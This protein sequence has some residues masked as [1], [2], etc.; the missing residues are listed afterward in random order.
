MRYRKQ[1][2]YRIKELWNVK[3]SV[4]AGYDSDTIE[5]MNKCFESDWSMVQKPK[6][7]PADLERVKAEMKKSYWT[8]RDAFKF[9]ASISSSTGS[10][11]FGL[12]LNSYTDYLKHAGV[13]K[14]KT[15]TFAD[16]D[17]MFFTITKR[18][19]P[20]NLSPGNAVIRYQFLE[21]M[22][23]IGLKYSKIKDPAEAVKHFLREVVE[24]SLK[25]GKAEDFRENRY[26][27]LE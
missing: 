16:T 21:I 17:T 15:V 24:N 13:Y 3:N 11:T 27:T 22:L 4:F 7:D 20:T 9:Y 23:K 2:Q 19:K 6:L 8:I 12:T 26:W 14:E 10:Q 25:N 5:L 1:V 18:E